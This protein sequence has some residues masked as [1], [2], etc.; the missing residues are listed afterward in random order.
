[1]YFLSLSSI[2]MWGSRLLLTVSMTD[3]SVLHS[4]EVV[5]LY[6][7]AKYPIYPGLYGPINTVEVNG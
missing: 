6:P 5:Q 7:Q 2:I 4:V 1:M 3:I